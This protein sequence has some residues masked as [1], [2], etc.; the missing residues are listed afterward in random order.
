MNMAHNSFAVHSCSLQRRSAVISLF[1]EPLMNTFQCKWGP[2]PIQRH[3]CAVDLIT[4]FSEASINLPHFQIPSWRVG[5]V[6]R[7][8]S[9]SF[10]P[11]GAVPFASGAASSISPSLA[12]FATSQQ[13][14]S[15]HGLPSSSPSVAAAS[16]LLSAFTAGLSTGFSTTYR[17]SGAAFDLRTV[18]PTIQSCIDSAGPYCSFSS[19]SFW[20]SSSS[21]LKV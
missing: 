4:R 19:F 11:L 18:S 7:L 9:T 13:Q 16:K 10:S 12:Q 14:P 8:V 5:T 2:P 6:P 15:H 1:R 20:I 3:I 21:G 17:L